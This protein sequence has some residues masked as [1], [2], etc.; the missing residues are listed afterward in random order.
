[1]LCTKTSLI[2][3]ALSAKGQ[4]WGNV[5]SESDGLKDVRINCEDKDLTR[6]LKERK[7]IEVWVFLKLRV[8]VK[9]YTICRRVFLFHQTTRNYD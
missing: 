8:N 4:R 3:Q 9:G 2:R 5:E 1:M 6:I 7:S